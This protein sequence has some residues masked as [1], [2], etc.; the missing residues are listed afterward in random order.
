MLKLI[1]NRQTWLKKSTRH[2]SELPPNKKH[3]VYPGKEVLVE[4]YKTI[5][6]SDNIIATL[7]YGQGTWVL[8]TP[9]FDGYKPKEESI[10]Q[11]INWSDFDAK[12]SKHFIVGEVTNWDSRRIPQSDQIK[13]NIIRLAY[14]LDKVR[15][16]Y[17]HPIL[18]NSWYRPL[19]INRQIG[20]SDGSQHVKGLA[21]DIRPSY[22]SGVKFEQWLDMGIW[23]NRAL[24]Y[25]QRAGKGFTH[26]DLRSGRIRW[27]Y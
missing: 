5:P 8:Y 6:D 2:S 12:I 7:A 13:K 9:H 17:G 20:S 27:N 18:V 10:I 4:S 14:E 23:R 3:S 1:A 25:G 16:E 11:T 19:F 22:G 15:D 24:G 26:L 21:A